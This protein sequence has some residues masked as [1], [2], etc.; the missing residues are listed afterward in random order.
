M[1]VLLFGLLRL[2]MASVLK[3]SPD[4]RKNEGN[5]SNTQHSLLFYAVDIDSS[6]RLVTQVD[7]NGGNATFVSLVGI[8]D[9]VY[10]TVSR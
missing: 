4:G 1:T 3:A 7:S 6:C 10:F 8:S 5:H 2:Y 9:L